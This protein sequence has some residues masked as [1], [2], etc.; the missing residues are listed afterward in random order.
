MRGCCLGAHTPQNNIP[1]QIPAAQ[2]VGP[3]GPVSQVTPWPG[4]DILPWGHLAL[5]TGTSVHASC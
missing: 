4:V 2:E 5:A 3:W 1:L